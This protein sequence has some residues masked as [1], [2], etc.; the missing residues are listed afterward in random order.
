METK[1]EVQ[2]AREALD[3]LE[4]RIHQQRQELVA[5]GVTGEELERDLEAMMAQH[6]RIRGA[7]DDE[8]SPARRMLDAEV[9]VLSSMFER[10]VASNERRFARSPQGQPQED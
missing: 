8:R 5:H 7:L 3:D 10:W 2:A 6:G 4:A 9:A 1:T